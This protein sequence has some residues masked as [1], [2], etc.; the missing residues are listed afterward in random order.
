MLGTLQSK[1]YISNSIVTERCKQPLDHFLKDHDKWNTDLFGNTLTMSMVDMMKYTILLHVSLG[2]QKLHDMNVLHRGGKS[3]FLP[4]VR[5][6]AS[7]LT[8][9]T[10]CCRRYQGRQH[11]SGRRARDL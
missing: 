3:R 4:K 1:T 8:F 10:P 9:A 2:L 7:F 5:L 11:P 6:Q